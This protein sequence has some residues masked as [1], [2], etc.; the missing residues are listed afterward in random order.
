MLQFY[1]THVSADWLIC[2][3]KCWTVVKTFTYLRLHY[4]KLHNTCEIYLTF[5]NLSSS[6][7][8]TKMIFLDKSVIIPVILN[9]ECSKTRFNIVNTLAGI[10]LHYIFFLNFSKL[11]ILMSQLHM[12]MSSRQFCHFSA[13]VSNL[14][15]YIY[16]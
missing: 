7:S 1:Y 15:G 3:I 8:Y 11:H 6:I 10:W 16:S 14:Q 12:V 13:T 2:W 4:T 9:W 5:C